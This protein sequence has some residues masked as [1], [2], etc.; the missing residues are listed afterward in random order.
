MTK[1]KNETIVKN[2]NNKINFFNLKLF[3]TVIFTLILIFGVYYIITVNDLV[4]KGFRLQELKIENNQFGSDNKALE[5]SKTTLESYN[6]LNERAFGLEMVAVGE[7]DYLA[8]GAGIVAK[9]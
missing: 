3:N 6:H 5:L 7:I 1:T 8:P 2:K 9:K 4:A